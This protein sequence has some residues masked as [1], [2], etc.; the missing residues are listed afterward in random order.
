MIGFPSSWSNGRRDGLYEIPESESLGNPDLMSCGIQLAAAHRA[1]DTSRRLA[2]SVWISKILLRKKLSS[3][4]CPL[5]GLLGKNLREGEK[6]KMGLASLSQTHFYIWLGTRSRTRFDK[7]I[8][9]NFQSL[10]LSLL[11]LTIF[12]Q[13]GLDPSLIFIK[14]VLP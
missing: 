14:V 10:S 2:F 13:F 4:G 5:R 6:I 9:Y 3:I 12:D 7:I 11:S 8:F 1:A